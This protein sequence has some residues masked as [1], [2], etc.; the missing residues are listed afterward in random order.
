M[1]EPFL[2]FPPFDIWGRAKKTVGT[3]KNA[4]LRSA[5]R[6]KHR[7]APSQL[8]FRKDAQTVKCVT[9]KV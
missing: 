2:D 6:N 3:R 4:V 5:L 7:F 8:S 1:V 9:G